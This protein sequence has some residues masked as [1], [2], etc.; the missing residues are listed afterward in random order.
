M[1]VQPLTLCM[2]LSVSSKSF[3]EP[4]KIIKK[5]SAILVFRPTVTIQETEKNSVISNMD[6][7]LVHLW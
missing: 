4:N 5:I 1:Q 3:R 7:K 6:S 2:M